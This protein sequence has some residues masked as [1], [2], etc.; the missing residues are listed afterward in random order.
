MNKKTGKNSKLNLIV[1]IAAIV[2]IAIAVITYK[3]HSVMDEI[4]PTPAPAATEA[5]APQQSAEPEQKTDSAQPTPMFTYKDVHIEPKHGTLN[6]A[7]VLEQDNSLSVL[8]EETEKS[9]I[10]MPIEFSYENVIDMI[11]NQGCHAYNGI[12][13]AY[14]AYLPDGTFDEAVSFYVSPDTIKG[15]A[16]GT[17]NEGNIQDSLEDLYVNSAFYA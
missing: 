16:D 17:V 10:R 11:L 12:G 2:I 13:Y 14:Y 6:Y 4:A 8:V 9:S 3:P 5:P 7:N 15:I 1:G